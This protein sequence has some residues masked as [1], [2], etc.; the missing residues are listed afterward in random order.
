M[1]RCGAGLELVLKVGNYEFVW[2]AAKCCAISLPLLP[3]MG[4]L[5]YMQGISRY[6]V[7]RSVADASFPIRLPE[8]F[9]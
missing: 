9:Q 3:R 5:T 2:K 7:G 1:F 8:S 6:A 4:P